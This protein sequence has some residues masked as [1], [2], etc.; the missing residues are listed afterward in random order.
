M[1]YIQT[2]REPSMPVKEKDYHKVQVLLKNGLLQV[3]HRNPLIVQPTGVF[4]CE[5]DSSRSV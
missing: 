1:I 3:V 2:R 4:V 5:S